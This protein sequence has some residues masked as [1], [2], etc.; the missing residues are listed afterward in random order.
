MLYNEVCEEL[1]DT[2]TFC[3]HNWCYVDMESCKT[4]SFERVYRS[5]YFD[6]S[7]EMYFPSDVPID[8]FYSYTTCNSTALD[9]EMDKPT[10]SVLGGVNIISLSSDIP[11]MAYKRD[12]A[13]E[14]IRYSNSGLW[15][16]EY[17]NDSIPFEGFYID[18]VKELMKL[19]NGDIATVNYTH[20]SNN[21]KSMHPESS[22]TAVIQDIADGLVDMAVGPFWITGERLRLAAF[23]LPIG[24]SLT[25]MI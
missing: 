14:I 1:D 8:L 15:M 24:K 5:I 25:R 7:P 17:K 20:P 9:G 4:N 16:N 2:K 6:E 11:P 19:S 18:Y 21:A 10:H 12:D 22:G 13:G 23:T 3:L